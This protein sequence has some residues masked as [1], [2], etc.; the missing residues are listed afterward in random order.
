MLKKKNDRV[1]IQ[2]RVA[3]V[4]MNPK[5][6]FQKIKKTLKKEKPIKARTKPLSRNPPKITLM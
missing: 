6:I 4:T 1:S 5:E 2:A 3:M